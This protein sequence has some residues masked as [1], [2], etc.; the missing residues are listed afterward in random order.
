MFSLTARLLIAGSIVLASF[1]GI[2][3]YTLD[4]AFRDQSE[5]SLR[6]RLQAHGLGL[7]ASAELADIGQIYIPDTLPE[8]R[9]NH[10][11][12]G[13]YAQITSNNGQHRWQS[14]SMHAVSVDLPGGAAPGEKRIQ[15]MKA[16]GHEL[17][18]I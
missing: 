7:I 2:T 5:Q 4:H 10:A 16:D 9:Y 11:G 17:Y 1:L 18:A 6:E 13:V 12:S 14:P 15:R 8:S 3:G